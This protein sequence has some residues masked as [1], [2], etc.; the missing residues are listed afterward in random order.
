MPYPID[1]NVENIAN[2]APDDDDNKIIMC[3]LTASLTVNKK[4]SS[5]CYHRVF[6]PMIPSLKVY[7]RLIDP[8][9]DTYDTA[10]PYQLSTIATTTQTIASYDYNIFIPF[11]K[12]NV[13]ANILE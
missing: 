12:K 7:L 3:T 6:H 1:C 13:P 10:Q 5:L 8:S 4:S 2:D 11:S 9:F